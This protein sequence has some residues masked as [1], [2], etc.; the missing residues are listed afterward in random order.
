MVP[1]GRASFWSEAHKHCPPLLVYRT[2]V[3]GCFLGVCVFY[4]G[5]F[6]AWCFAEHCPFGDLLGLGS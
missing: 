3:G 2:A 6:H 1:G 5:E 4:T